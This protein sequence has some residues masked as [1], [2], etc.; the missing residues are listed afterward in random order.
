MKGDPDIVKKILQRH[1][2]QLA[3]RRGQNAV[4][5]RGLSEGEIAARK[6]FW[7]S[8]AE[9]PGIRKYGA[10]ARATLSPG[11]TLVTGGWTTKDGSPIVVF[12]TPTWVDSAGN[13]IEGPLNGATPDLAMDTKIASV[14]AEDIERLGLGNFLAADNKSTV[15]VKLSDS[16]FTSLISAIEQSSGANMLGMPRVIS[17][18]QR[19]QVMVSYQQEEMI[20]GKNQTVGPSV[21]MMPLLSQDGASVDLGVIVRYS[22][23]AISDSK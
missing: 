16:E 8:L 6:D 3:A 17:T 13:K 15:A 19:P 12:V 10:L 14:L 20:A 2:E 1:D 7:D 22:E 9:E 21:D 11:E 18:E 5:G 4:R 23:A